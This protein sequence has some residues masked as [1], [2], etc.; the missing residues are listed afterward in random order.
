MRTDWDDIRPAG[1]AG[2]KDIGLSCVVNDSDG[3]GRKGWLSYMGGIA[4][5]KGPAQFGDAILKN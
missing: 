4:N 3:S 1:Y 5:G 2:S